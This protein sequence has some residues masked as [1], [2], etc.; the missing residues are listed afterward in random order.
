MIDGLV[1]NFPV[2]G[3]REIV[4][5]R[6]IRNDYVHGLIHVTSDDV[7]NSILVCV[8]AFD[9]VKMS[10]TFTNADYR[11]LVFNHSVIAVLLAANVCL[12]NLY[13]ASE[14]MVCFF[15]GRSDAMA[16]IPGGLVTDSHHS[17]NL[18]R[19]HSLARF[20]NE[21]SHGEPLMQGK[22]CVMEHRASDHGELVAA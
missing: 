20:A 16:E 10:A 11:S 7:V 15:H 1:G 18:I 14:L 6:F 19:G 12:V 4:E 9:E 21:V 8:G 13:G 17:L 3:L 5:P 2:L 22:V